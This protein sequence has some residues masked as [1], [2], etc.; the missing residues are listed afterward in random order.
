MW[1]TNSCSGGGGEGVSPECSLPLP[2]TTFRTIMFKKSQ[3]YIC[4]LCLLLAYR[5]LLTGQLL[6][7][8]GV[9]EARWQNFRL[10]NVS[11]LTAAAATNWSCPAKRLLRRKSTD[12]VYW[13][14]R[15][16]EFTIQS[17]QESIINSALS[18][19]FNLTVKFILDTLD[20]LGHKTQ[21]Q[22]GIYGEI[23]NV[24]QSC[25]GQCLLNRI[26]FWRFSMEIVMK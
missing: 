18:T 5:L 26:Y 6:F 1:A 7:L 13:T 14:H 22:G 3:G 12:T 8:W 21:H 17:N 24:R 4:L 19:C 23:T 25:E 11:I 16:R 2:P 9:R 20:L 15:W 10:K